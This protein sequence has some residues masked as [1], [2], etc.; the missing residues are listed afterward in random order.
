MTDKELKKLNRAE[1]L[2]L[3]LEQTKRIDELEK[4]LEIKNKEL[5]DRKILLGTVGSIAEASLRLNEVFET[6]QKAADQYLLNVKR[7][8]E[9]K[10]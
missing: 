10:N 5:A 1:L 8:A 7:I 4:V 2:E 3:L 9:E 6:A